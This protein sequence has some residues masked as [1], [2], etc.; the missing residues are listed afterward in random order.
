[1]GCAGPSM[2]LRGA[3]GIADLIIAGSVEDSVF[4]APP[5]SPVLGRL[6]RVATGASGAFAGQ[7]GSL[8]GWSAGGWR[9][10]VPVEGMRLSE[11][12]SGLELA[13]RGGS[14]TSGSMRVAEVLVAGA[15]VLGGRQ[16]AIADVAGGSAIDGQARA[17]ISQ[18]LSALRS[19]G[20]IAP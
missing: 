5:A 2:I 18:I 19:H 20:L 10:I 15:K 12:V 4:S 14:W 8:A 7:D 16:A 6:Y 17:A 9:F 3:L 1:M 13:Y 11:R